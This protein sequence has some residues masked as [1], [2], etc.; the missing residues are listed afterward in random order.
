MQG[1]ARQPEYA[2]LRQS[3]IKMKVI[4]ILTPSFSPLELRDSPTH[5]A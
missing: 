1:I 5:S 2:E 4:G 3:I